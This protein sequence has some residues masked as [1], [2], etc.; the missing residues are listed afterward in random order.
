[1]SIFI[2]YSV[3][4]VLTKTKITRQGV[5]AR[6]EQ[7]WVELH[8]RG[9]CLNHLKINFILKKIIFHPSW[10]THA[11]FNTSFTYVVFEEIW[12]CHVQSLAMSGRKNV[13]YG[14][15]VSLRLE[16]TNANVFCSNSTLVSCKTTLADTQTYFSP[17]QAGAVPSSGEARLASQLT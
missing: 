6:K 15:T 9:K 1:M 16:L 14:K 3:L 2:I 11:A 12:T 7:N 5:K 4:I 17:K 13:R 10:Q 8:L